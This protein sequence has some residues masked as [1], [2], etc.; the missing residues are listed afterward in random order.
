MT[1]VLCVVVVVL[2]VLVVIDLAM[3]SAVVRRLRD[4]AADAPVPRL[5][6]Q[7]GDRVPDFVPVATSS[8]PLGPTDL[9]T[10]E[11]MIAFLSAT[12]PHCRTQLPRFVQAA[13]DGG[14]ARFVA[15]IE[16]DPDR[17]RDLRDAVEGVALLAQSR[18]SGEGLIAAFGIEGFPTFVALSDG[19]VAA[20]SFTSGDI[21]SSPVV[22]GVT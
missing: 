6:V 12:C 21:V 13:A 7:P 16:G 1:T 15:V 3:T 22:S 9:A 4:G 17:A 8:G 20:A 14:A 2:A 10:G 11:W 5:G 19:E 18:T